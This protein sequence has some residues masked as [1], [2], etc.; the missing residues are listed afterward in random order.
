MT[1][2]PI[3]Y[4]VGTATAPAFSSITFMLPVE[5]FDVELAPNIFLMYA[6]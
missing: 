1:I 5:N 6:T 3:D 2:H 4:A